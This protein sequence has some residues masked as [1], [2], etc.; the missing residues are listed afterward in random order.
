MNN[1]FDYKRRY[2]ASDG[3][4]YINMCIPVLD[5]SNLKINS[6]DALNQDHNGRLD[7]FTFF[8][9]MRNIDDIDL[10]MYANHIYN[11]FAVKEN[12]VLFVP[13]DCSYQTPTEPRLID[14]TTLSQKEK[15]EKSKT[16]S[17]TVKMLHK[18]LN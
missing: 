9:A 3:E 11:P 17:E 16:Y 18:M 10:I 7:R 14:G 8:N 6:A 4:E 2:I 12:D 5:I 1:L 13:V 15:N